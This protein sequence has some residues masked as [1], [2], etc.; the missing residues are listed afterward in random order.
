MRPQ[1]VRIMLTGYTDANDLVDAINSGVVYKYVTK[2]WVNEELK[3]TVKRALQHYET[4]KAQRQ[5][6]ARCER[7]QTRLKATNEGVAEI[8]MTMLEGDHPYL[9][10]HATRTASL[11]AAIGDRFNLDWQDRDTLTLSARLHNAVFFRVRKEVFVK[12]G[13]LTEGDMEIMASGLD[14]GVRMLENVPD[15]AD[16]AG[17]LR[18]QLERFDGS[19]RPLGFSGSQIPLITRIITAAGA[20][21]KMRHPWTEIPAFEHGEAIMVLK[22]EAGSRFDPEV[23]DALADICSE[24]DRTAELELLSVG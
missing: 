2:P 11:S 1:T 10:D 18:F 21:D 4:T 6:Q 13:P 16:V 12:H 22:S 15:L 3:Q 17:M 7:L 9:R 8:I 5:L 14:H 24:V 19:G 23:I 20:Y